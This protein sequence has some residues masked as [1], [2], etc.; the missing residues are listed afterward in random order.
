V[1]QVADLQLLVVE[2][3]TMQ[4]FRKLEVW[5]KSH[6]L[7][8]NV[9]AITTDFPKTE[10]FGVTS[11]ARRAAV[12]IAANIAEGSARRGDKEFA[13]F[14]H[15]SLGSASELEYFSILF[16]DLGLL[17]RDDATKIGADAAEIKRMLSGL[18]ASLSLA[19]TKADYR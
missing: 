11:Q 15:I 18:I 13:R 2:A 10:I 19:A 6:R 7:A 1:S 3:P 16:G 12:S 5:Q 9:Y 17:K 4:D 8:L 14:L